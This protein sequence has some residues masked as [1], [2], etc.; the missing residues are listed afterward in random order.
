MQI[1]IFGP[2][3]FFY[4]IIIFHYIDINKMVK[5]LLSVYIKW[6]WGKILQDHTLVSMMRCNAKKKAVVR[7]IGFVMIEDETWWLTSYV[8]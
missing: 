1:N 5:N 6:Y 2:Y 4:T 7:W 8:G 3:N